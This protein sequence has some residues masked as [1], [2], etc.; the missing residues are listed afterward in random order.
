MLSKRNNTNEYAMAS[1]SAF[2]D[3]TSTLA[4]SERPLN[5]KDGSIFTARS[6]VNLPQNSYVLPKND[7]LQSELEQSNN[8]PI[9]L[10]PEYCQHDHVIKFDLQP[11]FMS[12]SGL[13]IVVSKPEPDGSMK[14]KVSRKDLQPFYIEGKKV[15]SATLSDADH[16]QIYSLHSKWTSI[17]THYYAK[18]N[19]GEKVLNLRADKIFKFNLTATFNNTASSQNEEKVLQLKT[20]LN[21]KVSELRDNDG[22]LLAIVERPNPSKMYKPNEPFR[23]SIAPK[24]DTSMVMAIC[25]GMHTQ[26][27]T[28]KVSTYYLPSTAGALA[29]S[30]K[31]ST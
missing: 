21:T 11:L 22:R 27:L 10:K 5:T 6:E 12:W 26:L 2:D 16:K 23:V 1:T 25:L 29:A 7:Q 19:Q 15:I 30:T 28:F 8:S 13:D 14:K 17:H 9:G 3:G 31:S 4:A 24:V 18:N 20:G